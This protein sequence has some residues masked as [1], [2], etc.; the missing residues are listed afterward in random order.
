MAMR[1]DLRIVVVAG[2]TPPAAGTPKLVL[3][4]NP[5]NVIPGQTT[6]VQVKVDD[7]SGA[8]ID[9]PPGSFLVP[10][11][12]VPNNLG[13]QATAAG[14]TVQLAVPASIPVGSTVDLTVEL[15]P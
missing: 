3:V 6:T 15:R 12:G 14:L 13:I 9:P 5:V 4:P 8:L 7:G 11:W 2:P 1:T 10:F